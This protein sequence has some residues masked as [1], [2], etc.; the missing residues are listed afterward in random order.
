MNSIAW[1]NFWRP[2]PISEL[3]SPRK[4]IKSLPMDLKD[5]S[6]PL[7]NFLTIPPALREAQLAWSLRIQQHHPAMSHTVKSIQT[8]GTNNENEIENDNEPMLI[9]PSS[10]ENRP[11][12]QAQPKSGGITTEQIP[13]A[14]RLETHS[15]GADRDSAATAW[16]KRGKEFEGRWWERWGVWRRWSPAA[17]LLQQWNTVLK[18]YTWLGCFP[19]N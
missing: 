6:Q 3:P 10:V 13:D 7:Q 1:E 9:A 5:K 8:Y 2:S 12:V 14:A 4:S 11:C 16:I 15:A 18:S 17:L 19:K